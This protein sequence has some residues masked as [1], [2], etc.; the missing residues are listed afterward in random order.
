MSILNVYVSLLFTP[1]RRK[2]CS[3]NFLKYLHYRSCFPT[4]DKL[5]IMAQL[6]E[7]SVFIISFIKSPGGF[8]RKIKI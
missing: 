2:F 7:M 3:K 5:V 4:V 1:K 8:N 6:K